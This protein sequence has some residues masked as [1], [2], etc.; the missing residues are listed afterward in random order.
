MDNHKLP[1]GLLLSAIVAVFFLTVAGVVG[2][3]F[4]DRTNST[5][6]ISSLLGF[7]G[8]TIAGILAIVSAIRYT[9]GRVNQTNQRVE[10]I[11]Q[12][13]ATKVDQVVTE[14]EEKLANGTN[15]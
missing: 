8:T 12:H 14:H 3:F 5:P 6:L 4:I 11:A 2:A 1:A 7:A 9:N 13:V 15:P 10:D